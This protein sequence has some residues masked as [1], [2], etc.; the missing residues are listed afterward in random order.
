MPSKAFGTPLPGGYDVSAEVTYELA[1]P[2][3]KLGRGPDAVGHCLALF[4]GHPSSGVHLLLE[5]LLV[6]C[7]GRRTGAWDDRVCDVVKK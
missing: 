2:P 1:P 7:V 5:L 6:G 3:S 4:D